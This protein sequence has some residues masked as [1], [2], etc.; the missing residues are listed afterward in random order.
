[1]INKNP[2]IFG[3]LISFFIVQIPANDLISSELSWT[4]NIENLSKRETNSYSEPVVAFETVSDTSYWVGPGDKISIVLDNSTKNELLNSE[5]EINLGNGSVF[6]IDGMRL[7]SAKNHICYE[8]KKLRKIERCQATL[9][10]PRTFYVKVVGE[11]SDPGV[12]QS[13]GI[14]NIQDFVQ[15]AGGFSPQADYRSIEVVSLKTKDTVSVSLEKALLEQCYSCIPQISEPSILIVK[16]LAKTNEGIKVTYGQKTKLY[17][18]KSERIFN[19]IRFYFG[20]KSSF[21]L[22]YGTILY[23]NGQV[24]KIT[25]NNLADTLVAGDE[26]VLNETVEKVYIGGAV[27]KPGHFDFKVGGTIID[28]IGEAGLTIDMNN[29]MLV[30]QYLNTNNKIKVKDLTKVA[31]VNGVYMVEESRLSKAN[32]VLTVLLPIINTLI[33]TATLLLARGN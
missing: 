19:L 29:K 6:K 28:Y 3:L 9:L 18:Q 1:M 12:Y 13:N 7:D 21:V 30:Y 32:K 16:S 17:P 15:L 4:G 33:L 8:I 24:K 10:S 26:L 27:A 25:Q 31:Q 5:G 2:F 20:F 14:K 22:S 23:K 11:V